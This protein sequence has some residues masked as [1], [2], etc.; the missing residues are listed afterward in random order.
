M[1]KRPIRTQ[2]TPEDIEQ[3]LISLAVAQARK[4]LAEGT[5]PAST[6]NYFLKLAST[7][8]KIEREMMQK[9]IELLS[10]KADSIYRTEDEKRAYTEVIDAIKSYGAGLN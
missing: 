3:E 1:A 10:A 4:Q 2:K 8:E 9:Q 7:K 6:V 5:A